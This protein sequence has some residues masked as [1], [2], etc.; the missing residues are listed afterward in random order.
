MNAN[1]L[2]LI[3]KT[4][5]DYFDFRIKA[6]RHNKNIICMYTHTHMK[7]LNRPL[8]AYLKLKWFVLHILIICEKYCSKVLL[9]ASLL[10]ST[11]IR[12]MY[13]LRYIPL[14]RVQFWHFAGF[15]IERFYRYILLFGMLCFYFLLVKHFFYLFSSV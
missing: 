2:Q 7:S 8:I 3:D 5:M 1:C 4:I 11:L 6:A 15:L 14:Y 9:R 12:L 13:I 10:A